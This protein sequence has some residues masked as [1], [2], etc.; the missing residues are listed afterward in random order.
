MSMCVF[1]K[2]MILY[3]PCYALYYLPSSYRAEGELN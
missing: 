2:T 3:N 1:M